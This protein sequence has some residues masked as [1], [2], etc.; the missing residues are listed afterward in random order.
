MR[1]VL[2]IIGSC[3]FLASLGLQNAHGQTWSGSADRQDGSVLL[4]QNSTSGAIQTQAGPDGS[5]V[6]LVKAAVTGKLLTIELLYS[7]PSNYE[8]RIYEDYPIEQVSYIDDATSQR[9][10]VVKDQS[11]TWMASPTLEEAEVQKFSIG[12]EANEPQVVWFKFPA[13]PE[14]AQTISINIPEVGPFDGVTVQR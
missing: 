8:D 1:L 5:Q 9:Y 13:P 4:A 6:N 7:V 12:I 3:F 2:G 14:S 11:G 10:G